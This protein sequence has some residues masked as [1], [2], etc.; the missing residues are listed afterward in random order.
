[1]LRGRRELREKNTTEERENIKRD[2]FQMTSCRR[3]AQFGTILM[4]GC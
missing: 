3:L 4:R 1:M 2:G